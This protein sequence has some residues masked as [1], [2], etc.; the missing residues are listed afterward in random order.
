MAPKFVNPFNTTK[1][2]VYG[3]NSYK[4]LV[5]KIEAGNYTRR[6]WTQLRKDALDTLIEQVK[7]DRLTIEEYKKIEQARR[8]RQRRQFQREVQ[9]LG[10]IDLALSIPPKQYDVVYYPIWYN[11]TDSNIR[12]DPNKE[13][14]EGWITSNDERIVRIADLR[15]NKDEKWKRELARKHR[16]FE[17]RPHILPPEGRHWVFI[18]SLGAEM[19]LTGT[20]SGTK[21]DIMK[22]IWYKCEKEAPSSL[23]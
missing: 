2:V 22:E 21:E 3:S 11:C 7:V 5:R 4:R 17:N 18:E 12:H 9:T 15:K 16:D 1:R 8:G 6:G 19:R 13:Y 20:F 23:G 14:T 10:E